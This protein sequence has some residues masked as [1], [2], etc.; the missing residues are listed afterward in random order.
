MTPQSRIYVAGHNGMVG[1]AIVRALN[2][3]G[4]GKLVTVD[5]AHLDLTNQAATQ[6]FFAKERPQVVFLA[7]AKVGGIKANIDFPAEFIYENLMIETNVLAAA[8]KN[9]CELM[10]MIG[11]SCIYPREC[12]QPM[13]EEYLLSGP[14]E[15]TNEGYALAKIAGIHLAQYLAS[16]KR[17]EALCPIPCNLYGPDNSFDPEYSHVLAA[18]VR[19]FTE[20]EE[21]NLPS[22]A[23][24]GTGKAR[25][26]LLHA[27]DFA[28]ALLFLIE[29]YHSSEIINVGFGEDASI[30]E[31]AQIVAQEVGYTGDLKW[32][33]AMPEG[34]PR[35]LLDISRIRALGWAPKRNLHDGVAELVA[36]FRQMRVA[37][38]V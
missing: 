32:H 37:N 24:W 4:Y 11:S 10:V 31:L 21:H 35:K 18:L 6:H 33:P 8:A 38:A 17:F 14:L 34:M 28:D 1:K 20:A 12:L 29:R 26:E 30:L 3:Q 19:K 23:L 22:V 16:A 5:R 15:S 2:A 7:A 13:K 25:R 36:A 27:D 9:G